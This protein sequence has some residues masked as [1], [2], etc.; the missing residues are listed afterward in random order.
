MIESPIWNSD[1]P[2]MIS[3]ENKSGC[4]Q[5]IQPKAN[6]MVDQ[7]HVFDPFSFLGSDSIYSITIVVNAHARLKI[8]GLR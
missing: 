1:S 6:H 2:A 3:Q 8:S 7:T 5:N 4:Q